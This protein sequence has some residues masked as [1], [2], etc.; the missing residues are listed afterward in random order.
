MIIKDCYLLQRS[1]PF[2]LT[3]RQEVS[4]DLSLEKAPA[5]PH[6]LLTGLVVGKTG[7]ASG[8]TVKVLDRENRPVIHAIT[9]CHGKFSFDNL[10]TPGI[11]TVIA[12]ADGYKVSAD[13]K[14]SLEAYRPVNLLVRLE[15][16]GMT[17]SGTVYGVCYD[18]LNQVLADVKLKISVDEKSQYEEA[19]TQSNEDGEYIV[20]GLTKKKYWMTAAK[21]GYI[22]PRRIPFEVFPGEISCLNV[23]L[24]SDVSAFDGTISGRLVHEGRPVANAVAALYQADG[25]SDVLIG[26][27]EANTAGSYL[28]TDV[29]PGNYI[30]KAK[31][32]EDCG[33]G[34]DNLAG[35]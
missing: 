17:D 10:L 32:Q 6:T 35:R 33:M 34:K 11:Y 24:Y 30:V 19:L 25:D 21:E 14:L 18:E 1:D 27:K 13:Y 9:E 20:Y 3:S 8:A 22:L 15:L 31:L 23:F 28:F 2:H 7:P 16:S 5:P 12:T 29:K 4:V 26:L